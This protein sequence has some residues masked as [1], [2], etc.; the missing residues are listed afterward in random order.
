MGQYLSAVY[1]TLPNRYFLSLPV[2]QLCHTSGA[3]ALWV[4]NRE[5]LRG[6]VENDLFPKWGVTYAASFYWLKVSFLHN[7]EAIFK[8]TASGMMTGELDLFHHRPYECL[9]LGYYDGK[10]THSGN[11][12]TLNPI[13]DNRVFISV[14]G[15]YS[16]KPPIGELLLD[17]MPGPTTWSPD[18]FPLVHE[19]CNGPIHSA[20]CT[21]VIACRQRVTD[22][23]EVPD[24]LVHELGGSYDSLNIILNVIVND[25]NQLLGRNTTSLK[26]VFRSFVAWLPGQLT[27]QRKSTMFK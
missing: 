3:L 23:K 17:Y 19:L 9:L 5:K 13:P 12:T 14:P 8:V 21:I 1:P 10:D 27:G 2:K 26:R 7:C 4:T 18:N 16:R 6:F 11:L 24:L 20:S 15:D 25:L 22:F